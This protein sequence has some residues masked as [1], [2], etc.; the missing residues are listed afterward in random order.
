MTN[1]QLSKIPPYIYQ[2]TAFEDILSGVATTNVLIDVIGEFIDME[3]SQ[4]ESMP[5]KVVF[6]MRD[7]RSSLS[8]KTDGNNIS[9]TLWGQF[10]SQLLKYERGHKFGPIVVILTIAKIR[11]AKGY[12]ITIQN[13]M[14]G[15]KL[16]INDNNIQEIQVFAKS[17]G[18][19]KPYESYNQRMSNTSSSSLGGSQDKFFQNAVV[20]TISE[21]IQLD[22]E[23]VCVTYGTIEKLFT[24]GWYYDGCP[25]C[26]RKADAIRIP[27]NCPGCGKFLK[28]VVPRYRVEIRVNYN[29]DNMKFLIKQPAVDLKELMLSEGKLNPMSIPQAVDDLVTKSLAFKVKV[30]PTYKRCSVIQVSEDSQLIC[31]GQ[32]FL[33]HDQ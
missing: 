33:S 1:K 22:H 29:H 32:Y 7:Q 25:Q 20:K 21:L 31:T 26:N 14:Y 16:F 6:S 3:M 28:E 17:L 19:G 24:N 13:T 11:E 12:P 30:H 18:S 23:S 8:A 4:L 15:S 5:K 10:A 9:C 27:F 2:F